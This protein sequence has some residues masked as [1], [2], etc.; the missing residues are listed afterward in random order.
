[1]VLDMKSPLAS[2]PGHVDACLLGMVNMLFEALARLQQRAVYDLGKRFLFETLQTL[3]C[4]RQYFS[5]CE[6]PSPASVSP[7]QGIA[8]LTPPRPIA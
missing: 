4:S 2:L 8:G 7:R 3:C 6:C 5:T 1:M